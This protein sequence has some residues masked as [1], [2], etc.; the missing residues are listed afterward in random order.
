LRP[1]KSFGV[2]QIVLYKLDRLSNTASIETP[3][4]GAPKMTN[5]KTINQAAAETLAAIEAYL[6]QFK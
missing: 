3:N 6:A 4:D 5:E 1:K 2:G